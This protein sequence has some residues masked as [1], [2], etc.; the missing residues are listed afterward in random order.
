MRFA[1]FSFVASVFVLGLY[2]QTVLG[3]ATPRR[4]PDIPCI[5][6]LGNSLTI[7]LGTIF[8]TTTPHS[9]AAGLGLVSPPLG[10]NFSTA[11]VGVQNT[12]TNVFTPVFNLARFNGS[13]AAWAG[14]TDING[15]QALP[16]ATWFGFSNLNVPPVNPPTLG[17]NEIFA[18]RFDIQGTFN[19]T[20]IQGLRVQYG[21]G[22]GTP[23]GLP[24]FN[25]LADPTHSSQYSTVVTVPGFGTSNWALPEPATYI[26]AFT[27]LTIFAGK[28][29]A[30]RMKRLRIKLGGGQEPPD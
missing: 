15:T 2:P 8:Q 13:D 3:C 16:G 4:P 19:P 28:C 11:E 21:S 17:V 30:E 18:I 7:E 22:L 24:D 9:C 14:G 10:L 25:H 12:A 26:Y 5:G 27:A 1:S 23:T 6:F 20:L 29:G